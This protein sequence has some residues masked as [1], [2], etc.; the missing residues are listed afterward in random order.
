[1]GTRT[2]D[3]TFCD[4]TSTCSHPDG[5]LVL[6]DPNPTL[7][8]AIR[9]VGPFQ[10]T[11]DLAP[12]D[13]ILSLMAGLTRYLESVILTEDHVLVRQRPEANH[14]GRPS[15]SGNSRCRRWGRTFGAVERK[16]SRQCYPGHF[17]AVSRRTGSGPN[18]QGGISD[19]KDYD[20]HYALREEL[21]PKSF[22]NQCPWLCS[23][24]RSRY[25]YQFCY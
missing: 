9:C 22:G 17:H 21:F 5:F 7:S 13:Q 11:N 4:R 20:S 18:N 15:R 12:V 1:M 10:N 8:K 24:R 23:E 14:S 19:D 6:V 3:W 25:R 16:H 2:Q